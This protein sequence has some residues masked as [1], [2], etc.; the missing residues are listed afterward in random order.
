MCVEYLPGPVLNVVCAQF[1]LLADRNQ[2]SCHEPQESLSGNEKSKV[3]YFPAAQTGKA[4]EFCLY[5][6]GTPVTVA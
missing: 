3:P 5:M 4:I 1:G 2:Y 6:E